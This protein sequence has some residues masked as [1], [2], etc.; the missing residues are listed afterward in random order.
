MKTT[1]KILLAAISM[2]TATWAGSVSSAD[3]P[4]EGKFNYTAC[5]SGTS[6][7]IQFSK[8]HIGMSYEFLGMT[9]TDPPGGLFDMSTFRC[10]GSNAIFDKQFSSIVT[11]EAVDAGGDKVLSYYHAGNDRKIIREVIAGTGKY[12]GIVADGSVTPIGPFPTIKP[13]TFQACN[14]QSGTYKLK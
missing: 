9:R 6:N 4:K 3:L 5:W 2:V 11:C 7:V 1:R 10:V 12:E 8:T 14:Q 13:G